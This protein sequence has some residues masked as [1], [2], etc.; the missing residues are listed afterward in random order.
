MSQGFYEML[1]V[2]ADAPPEK[3]RAA[4]QRRLAELVR[5]L[6]GARKQ[7]ADVSILEAQERELREAID[8]LGDQAR[9][10]RYDAF[11]RAVEGELPTDA[12]GLWDQARWS[13]VD[14]IAPL[15]VA[16]LRALTDLPVGDPLPDPT[17]KAARAP[18]PPV[19]APVVPLPAPRAPVPPPPRGITRPVAVVAAPER[20]D[21]ATPAGQVAPPLAAPRVISLSEDVQERTPA[22]R[23]PA[24]ERPTA[25]D[26]PT[27]DEA[28]SI[29]V[30]M[31]LPVVAAP[32][33]APRQPPPTAPRPAPKAPEPGPG[34]DDWLGD[35]ED[36]EDLLPSVSDVPAPAPPRVAAKPAA[37][38]SA[39]RAWLSGVLGNVTGR[40]DAAR[41]AT[42]VEED[43]DEPSVEVERTHSL[44][45]LSAAP[46][47]PQLD[48]VGRIA[49]RHGLSGR[50]L[51]EVRQLR[52]M[53]L[54][55]LVRTTRISSRFLLAIEED[56][57]E[58]LPNATFV[59]GYL[60]QVA[61]ALG[62]ADRGVVDGFMEQYKAHRG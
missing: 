60:K 19:A 33:S 39:A 11:R 45:V 62:V 54:E 61:E 35:D 49:R 15:A 30:S 32:R 20:E 13:L 14:P 59:R 9:R 10:R 48:D 22:A 56:D 34:L 29:S 23:A 3:I 4:Y 18:A 58:R 28:P 38:A 1:G 24:P 25:P 27:A 40:A 42:V 5:R 44:R 52:E 53:S 2:E 16:V 7:G 31:P 43:G 36:E 50:F 37:P 41:E 47:E 55:D 8:V 17:L 51:K 26:R 46:D 6:R 21:E 12:E 57:F